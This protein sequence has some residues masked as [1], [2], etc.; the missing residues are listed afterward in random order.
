MLCDGRWGCHQSAREI[1]LD[2]TTAP[3][4]GRGGLMSDPTL[5][6]VIPVYNEVA[7]IGQ[8]LD[9]VLVSEFEKQVVVVDDGSTDGTMDALGLWRL[10]TRQAIEVVHHPANRGKG[11]AIRTGLE[12]ARG[13]V[14]LIQDADL[15]YD[16]S[17]YARLLEPILH[18]ETDVVYGSRYQRHLGRLAWTPNRL[19][20]VLLN[21]MVRLLYGQKL[22]D[23]ATCY[24]AIRTDLLRRLDL[25]CE[26]FEF[27]PEVT[28]KL[29]RMGEWI[30]EV[31][32]TYTPRMSA[33]GKKIR[34]R[35]GVEAVATLIR[36]RLVPF[37]PLA[38]TWPERPERAMEASSWPVNTSTAAARCPRCCT[39]GSRS[40]PVPP[41]G[42]L[43]PGD[44]NRG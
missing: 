15:E 21:L 10:R 26:R 36:W 28:A 35:D 31:P 13:T 37:R 43:T 42:Q 5:T 25:R 38:T 23:E 6:V 34:W 24:K 16:P 19:C 41:R 8:L 14:T 2:E 22:S 40:A 7:T 33:D 4:R 11:A 29:C 12:L 27:C 39:P 3:F 30:K 17:E 18:G 1:P 44:R 20:V 32:I 9:A